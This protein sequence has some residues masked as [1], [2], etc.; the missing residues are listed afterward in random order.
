MHRN[1]D[2]FLFIWISW[3][4]H[5]LVSKIAKNDDLPQT[6]QQQLHCWFVFLGGG[7]RVPID[8]YFNIIS[9]LLVDNSSNETKIAIDHR[10]RYSLSQELGEEVIKVV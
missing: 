5:R 9:F 1:I 3:L 6:P 8:N 10:T 4:L 7:K 2:T